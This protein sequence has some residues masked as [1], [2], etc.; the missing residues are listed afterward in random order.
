MYHLKDEKQKGE[1]PSSK[2]N[3]Y[4]KYLFVMTMEGFIRE[5]KEGIK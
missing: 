5:N 1:T 2:V 4:V 3:R